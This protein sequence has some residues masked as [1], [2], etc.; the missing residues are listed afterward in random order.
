MKFLLL[1]VAILA[2]AVLPIQAALNAKMGKAVG[3]PL[4][5]T[6]L[7][8]LVGTLGVF[9]YLLIAR[10][11]FSTVSGLRNVHWTVYLGGLLGGFYVACVIILAPKLGVALTFG[12]IVAGQLVVSMIMDHFGLIGLPVNLISWQKLV[13]VSL[14]VTGVVLIRLF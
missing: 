14:I 5:A 13:G 3:D 1:S 4:Y 7:S 8:F 2:G 9:I 12:L 6:F 10:Q 11:D